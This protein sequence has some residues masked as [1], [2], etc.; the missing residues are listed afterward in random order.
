VCVRP[1]GVEMANIRWPM[2]VPEYALYGGPLLRACLRGPQADTC[3]VVANYGRTRL[4]LT[5]PNS[6]RCRNYHR[7]IPS[8]QELFRTC[9]TYERQTYIMSK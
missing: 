4:R 8:Q 1:S 3:D 9:G 7:R 5:R 2:C 6:T